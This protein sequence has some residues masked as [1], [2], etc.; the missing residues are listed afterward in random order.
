MKIAHNP[1]EAKELGFPSWVCESDWKGEM[2]LLKDG[3][4]IFKK[5]IW[6]NE[7]LENGFWENIY[8]ENGVWINGIRLNKIWEI[9]FEI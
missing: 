3:T 4:I 9:G 2:E 5:G 1:Q 8:L 7:L 6:E